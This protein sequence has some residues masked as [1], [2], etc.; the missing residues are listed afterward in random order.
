[1]HIPTK[2]YKTQ[3][4]I[5]V[6]VRASVPAGKINGDA[7]YCGKIFDMQ[8]ILGKHIKRIA[9]IIQPNE[10]SKPY[11][12]ENRIF[13]RRPENQQR[14]QCKRNG[15]PFNKRNPPAAFMLAFVTD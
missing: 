13:K 5:S 10:N 15:K 1:M 2:G 4:Q 8:C 12:V 14:T 9:D 3:G 6:N 11:I 7:G